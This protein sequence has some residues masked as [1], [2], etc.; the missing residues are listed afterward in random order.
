M[1]AIRHYRTLKRTGV[2]GLNARNG[3]YILQYNQRRFYPLVDDKVL[4]KKCLM[5]RGLAVPR[6]I[7]VIGSMRGAS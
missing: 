5:E 7:A 1:G 3:N 6:Q 2:L 4:C